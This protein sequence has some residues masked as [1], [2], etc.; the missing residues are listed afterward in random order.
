M[1]VVWLKLLICIIGTM[2][3]IYATSAHLH[4]MYDVP[5][6]VIGCIIAWTPLFLKD[7]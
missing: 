2:V 4:S 3:I 1:G 6:L 5:L 7:K